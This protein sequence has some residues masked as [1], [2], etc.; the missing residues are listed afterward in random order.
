MSE[1]DCPKCGKPLSDLWEL[2]GEGDYEIDCGWCEVPLK[3]RIMVS[4]SYDVELAAR[5]AAEGQ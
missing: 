1:A 5:G 3:I 4:V 2:G